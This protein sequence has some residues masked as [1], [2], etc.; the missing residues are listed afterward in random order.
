MDREQAIQHIV[1]GTVGADRGR[2]G[3]GVD[4]ITALHRRDDGVDLERAQMAHRTATYAGT[5]LA[6][7]DADG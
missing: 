2:A 4:L 6:G 1:D 7:K 3:F 5:V